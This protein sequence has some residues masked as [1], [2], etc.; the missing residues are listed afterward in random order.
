[1]ENG[2]TGAPSCELQGRDIPTGSS[3]FQRVLHQLHIHETWRDAAGRTVGKDVRR[4]MNS[5]K[6]EKSKKD[7]RNSATR[8]RTNSFTKLKRFLNLSSKPT[9]QDH[10]EKQERA[11][12]KGHV[13]TLGHGSTHRQA[14]GHVHKDGHGG[15]HG[16]DHGHVHNSHG[17]TS[18]HSIS[19]PPRSPQPPCPKSPGVVRAQLEVKDEGFRERSHSDSSAMKP[20]RKKAALAMT[21]QTNPLD[22]LHVHWPDEHQGEKLATTLRQRSFSHGSGERPAKP[23]LKK[24]S[25]KTVYY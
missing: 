1:M 8:E 12:A 21:E 3:D 14:H 15:T 22:H 10:I 24:S 16:Q 17:K 23:I 20:R 5:N 11:P 18:P 2:D 13:E 4:E 19:T 7:D 9:S 6:K 25:S